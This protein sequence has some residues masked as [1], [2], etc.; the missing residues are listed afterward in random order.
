MANKKLIF[1][2]INATQTQYHKF[3]QMSYSSQYFTAV[4]QSTLA[5]ICSS[6]T[7]HTLISTVNQVEHPMEH[8]SN[9]S[10]LLKGPILKC[11][12]INRHCDGS[13]KI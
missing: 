11:F 3:W 2:A 10:D 5:T 8:K 12:P 1:A 9:L 7:L 13:Y 6:L 4:E